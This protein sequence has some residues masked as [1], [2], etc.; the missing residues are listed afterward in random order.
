MDL[1]CSLLKRKFIDVRISHTCAAHAPLP[2]ASYSL[3][4]RGLGVPACAATH[5]SANRAMAL[6]T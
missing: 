5:H 6:S 4:E 3:K 2:I 1:R